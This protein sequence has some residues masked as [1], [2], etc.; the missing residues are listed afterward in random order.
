MKSCFCLVLFLTGMAACAQTPVW[1]QLP[2]SPGPNNIRHDDIYFTDP[3]NGWATQNNDIYRTTNGG[4]TWTTNLILANTHFRSICFA[5]PLAGFAG[6][7]GSNSYDA[8]VKNTNVMYRTFDG[9]VTWANVPGFAE[10][11][12]KG[13]CSFFVLDS[14][15]IYGAGRVRGPAFVIKSSDGGTN[16]TLQNLT[17]S[18]VMNGIM[19]IYFRDT[20]NGWVVGMDTNQYAS[21][22]YYGRI[23][24]TTNGGASWQVQVTTSIPDC[25]FWKMSWPS[26]DIGYVSLQQ[27]GAYSNLVFYK[28]TDGGDTWV[29]N[30]IPETSV[31]LYT[32]GYNF[33]LQGIGFVSTN[34]GWIGG[35]SGL[36]NYPSSFLHTTNGGATWTPAGFNDTFFVNRIRFLSPTLGFASGGNLYIYNVPL[37]VTSQ[38]QSQ[39]VVGPTNV[40]LIVGAVGNP[41]LAYQWRKDN[42]NLA[43]ATDATLNLTNALRMDSGTYS[44]FITNGFSTLQ[45]SNAVLRVLVPERFG[46]PAVLPGNQIQL[47]F[48]DADGGALLTTNDLATFQ[49][50]ASTNLTNWFLVTNTLTVTNGSVIFQD[51]LINAPQRFYKVLEQ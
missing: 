10:A 4:V 42:T 26:A 20:N 40:S 27:N 2:R 51:S 24:R 19:D 12:M 45:S 8:N 35:A 22:P 23:A 18:N 6:N 5:N 34:E 30:A 46:Q 49:V 28:T 15:H 36:P 31:G 13:L 9:G 37:D 50:F 47:L 38:P 25:Y 7:L 33:Y 14:Q 39:T 48:N 29:S 1:S 21:P 44:V 43:G 3:T 32:N 17:A 11:G 41:P 16:W